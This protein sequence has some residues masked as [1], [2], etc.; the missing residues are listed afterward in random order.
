MS[1]ANISFIFYTLTMTMTTIPVR[2]DG[3]VSVIY[4]CVNVVDDISLGGVLASG[5]NGKRRMS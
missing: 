5:G 2:V 1:S 3:V 4:F